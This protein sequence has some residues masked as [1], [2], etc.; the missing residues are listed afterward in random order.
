LKH[1]FG[2]KGAG[3]IS[4]F[5]NFAGKLGDGVV[6]NRLRERHMSVHTLQKSTGTFG[7]FNNPMVDL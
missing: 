7:V 5:V 3:V 1:G 6:L 2:I 4:F